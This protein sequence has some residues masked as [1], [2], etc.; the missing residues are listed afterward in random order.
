[1]L[2]LQ[3]KDTLKNIKTVTVIKRV[4]KRILDREVKEEGR[5]GVLV[6]FPLREARCG[7]EKEN[8]MS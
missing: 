8:K 1:M 4:H 3:P 6:N 2:Q 7:Y 5:R